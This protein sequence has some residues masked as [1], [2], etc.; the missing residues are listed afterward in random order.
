MCETG[1]W[2]RSDGHDGSRDCLISCCKGQYDHI[3]DCFTT[4]IQPVQRSAQSLG[5]GLCLCQLLCNFLVYADCP[6]TKVERKF[7]IHWPLYSHKNTSSGSTQA[8]SCL[9]YQLPNILCLRTFRA[10]KT[11]IQQVLFNNLA[12]KQTFYLETTLRIVKHQIEFV[13]SLFPNPS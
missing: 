8:R 4:V 2:C 7:I 11:S 13:L 1:S 5:H 12:P 10:G 9:F 6:K 3:I